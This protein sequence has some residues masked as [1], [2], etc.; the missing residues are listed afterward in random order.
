MYIH[1]RAVSHSLVPL[2][3]VTSDSS[4]ECFL[5]TL[6]TNRSLTS[7]PQQ[8]LARP[9]EPCRPPSALPT[10]DPTTATSRNSTL[11]ACELENNTH[12]EPVH[13]NDT[14]RPGAQP[15]R[16]FQ[17]N[18]NSILFCVLLNRTERRLDSGA[19]PSRTRHLFT[20]CWCRRCHWSLCQGCNHPRRV[21]RRN[22]KHSLVTARAGGSQLSCARLEGERESTYV[23]ALVISVAPLRTQSSNECQ[24]RQGG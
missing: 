2:R 15:P 3:G 11:A 12:A 22:V 4:A 24:R 16:F 23:C 10:T 19:W 18:K 13:R 6:T 20:P 14:D 7:T 8:A 9:Q 1:F 17:T 5:F 21:R